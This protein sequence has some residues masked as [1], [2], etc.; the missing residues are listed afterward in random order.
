[1]F[2]ATSLTLRL[3]AKDSHK[4]R[5]GV[6]LGL[7]LESIKHTLEQFEPGIIWFDQDNVITAMNAVAAETF[8]D[9]AEQLIGKEAREPVL[10]EL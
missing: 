6:H 4:A 10:A 5:P 3:S 8:G 7:M 2:L 1:M 9:G